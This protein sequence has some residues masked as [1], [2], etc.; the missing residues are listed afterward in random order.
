MPA[1]IDLAYDFLPKILRK[2][3]YAT[4]HIGKWHQGFYTEAYTPLGRGYDTTYGFLVGGED[5]YSQDSSWSVTQCTSVDLSRNGKPCVGMSAF[6]VLFASA[7]LCGSAFRIERNATGWVD[8]CLRAA[9]YAGENGTKDTATSSG[10]DRRYNGFTFT[11]EAVSII[12]SA[13]MTAKPMFMYFAIHNTHSPIEAPLRIQALYKD[14][15]WYVFI[16]DYLTRC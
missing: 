15:A 3:G 5:H 8:G 13:N 11:A 6:P 9:R 16:T 1:G 2:A 10:D 4:H 7:H 12:E 14:F